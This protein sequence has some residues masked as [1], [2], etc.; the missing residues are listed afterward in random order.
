L[1]KVFA[2]YLVISYTKVFIE[3]LQKVKEAPKVEPFVTRELFNLFGTYHDLKELRYKHHEGLKVL[4]IVIGIDTFLKLFSSVYNNFE[5]HFLN[6]V[7]HA[8][9]ALLYKKSLKL[10]FATNRT[11]SPNDISNIK[12]EAKAAN[13]TII[14]TGTGFLQTL[15]KLVV[16]YI[17][18]L[19]GNIRW[20]VFV[21]PILYICRYFYES[22]DWSKKLE[23]Q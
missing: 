8:Y 19:W 12:F 5:T 23:M 14:R 18:M 6:R 4:F 11:F 2:E 9:S 17:P 7:N 3:Y 15:F 20:A 13:K 22:S 21:V 1:C 10:T 16:L